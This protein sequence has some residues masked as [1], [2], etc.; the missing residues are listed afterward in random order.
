[1]RRR[2]AGVFGA[3]GRGERSRLS[4]ALAPECTTLLELGSL[5]VAF[6]GSVPPRRDPLCLFDG[7]LD[8]AGELATELG[9]TPKLNVEELLSIGYR[10]WNSDLVRRLRGDFFMLIWDRVRERGLLARDQLG[11]GCLYLHDAGGRLHFASEIN[12]LLTLLP[13]RPPPDRT[14][15]AHWMAVSNRPGSATVLAGVRRLNP[16]SMLLLGRDGVAERRYWVPRFHEP[17]R[18]G[19]VQALDQV[20]AGLDHAVGRRLS[21]E[22]TTGILMSGGLDSASVAAVAAERAPRRVAAFAGLFPD[23]PAVDESSLIAELRTSLTLPGA[24]ARVGSGGLLASVAESIEAWGVPPRAWGDF[25]TLPLLRAAASAGA[26]VVLGGDGGDELFASRI[27]LLA[28]LMRGGRPREALALALRLPGAGK[29]PPRRQ[30]ARV[31]ASRA[32]AGAAPYR[33]HDAIWRTRAK[34]QAP[35]WLRAECSRAMVESDDPLGWKR[36][37]APR[38]WAHAAHGLTHGVEEAGVFEHHRRRA[39]LAN[40][41]ARHPLFD[42]DLL[43]LVLRQPPEASFDPHRN[44][45]LL[46]EGMAGRLPDSVRLR[47]AKAWFDPLI[48]DCLTGPD[49]A[50][51]RRLLSDPRAELREYVDQHAMRATLLDGPAAQGRR[52]FAW[53]HQVWRLLTAECWLRAEAGRGRGGLPAEIVPSA[54]RIELQSVS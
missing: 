37:D 22:G 23:F 31:L 29:R 33:L 43:E 36:L 50:A 52:S 11:V 48:V 15:M 35:S 1:M 9:V 5:N 34:R 20:R 46:R 8:N 32:L 7:F 4:S 3:S 38:W 27:Y 18:V 17:Q 49:G 28:D 42:L 44:R 10:R 30:L 24:N 13:S 19:S 16:A 47:P 26:S 2:L 39:V 51:V 53:M 21:R 6:T 54:A 25:W 12:E 40:V 14:S 45:P 41:R